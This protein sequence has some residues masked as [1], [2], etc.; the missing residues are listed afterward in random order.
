MVVVDRIQVT[1]DQ[2][3]IISDE[4]LKAL[5]ETCKTADAMLAVD[6]MRAYPLILREKSSL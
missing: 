1:K 4:D 5:H 3:D 2:L 6:I